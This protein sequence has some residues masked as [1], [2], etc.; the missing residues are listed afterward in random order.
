MDFNKM[1]KDK[2]V[3]IYRRLLKYPPFVPWKKG[4]QMTIIHHL[5][6]RAQ[7]TVTAPE[8]V[9]VSDAEKLYSAIY[10]AENIRDGEETVSF[11]AKISKIHKLTNCNNEEYIVSSL[12]RITKLTIKYEFKKKKIVIFHIIDK[13]EFDPGTGILS[14]RMPKE[15]Y[16]A[17]KNKALTINLKNF[18][19]L[20][21][22]T[23]NLYGFLITNPGGRFKEDLL[24]ERAVITTDRKDHAQRSLKKGLEELKNNNIIKDFK[25]QKKDRQRYVVID[26]NGKN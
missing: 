20:K 1:K 19:D 25:I 3:K 22:G 4:D 23:K 26:K 15:T 14:I 2:N 10:C 16:Y 9:T 21:P 12:E 6:S 8:P 7:I 18:T 5:K 13:V 11:I 17:F 24:I